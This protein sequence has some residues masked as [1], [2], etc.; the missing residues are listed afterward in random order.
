[1]ARAHP[2]GGDRQQPAASTP[3]GRLGE[4]KAQINLTRPAI[5]QLR[6]VISRADVPIRSAKS[7]KLQVSEPS[8]VRA[9]DRVTS[10]VGSIPRGAH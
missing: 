9:A 8:T 1:M 7:E 2:R 10:Q 4:L 5:S 3:P 6:V